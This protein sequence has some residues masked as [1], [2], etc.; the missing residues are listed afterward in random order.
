M[1]PATK[2]KP[3]KP[4]RPSRGKRMRHTALARD[5]IDF[6][7]G[8]RVGEGDMVGQPLELM[9]FQIDFIADAFKGGV[10]RAILSVARR[11]T[12]TA[13]VAIIVLAALIGPLMVPNSLIVSAARSRLQASVVFEYCKKMIRLSGLAAHFTIRDAAKEIVCE[14]FG[15]TYRALAAEATTAVGFGMRLCIHDEL[16][17]VEGPRDALFEALTTAMGSYKDSLEIIISTQAANDDDLFS[18]LIDDALKGD[19]PAVVCH[20]HTAPKDCKLDDREAWAA[21][22]PAMAYGVRD[23]ADMERQSREAMRLPSREAAFRN[24]ALNQRVRAIGHFIPPDIWDQGARAVDEEVLR[25]GPC[26]AGLD[27]SSRRDLTSLAIV[28]QDDAGE[29][30]ARVWAWT[31]EETMA[32]RERTDKVPYSQWVREGIVEAL[33]GSVIDYELIAARLG[34]IATEYPIVT[35]NFDR[36]KI[37]E[38]RLQL[39]KLGIALPL[40]EHGQGFK[41]F[42]GAV[43]ALETVALNGELRHGGNPVLRWAVAN[44]AVSRDHAGNRKFDKRLE[45]R[46]IDPAVAVAMAMRGAVRPLGAPEI[47]A[48]IA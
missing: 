2:A 16:G 43:D 26:Y 7:H 20:L 9:D 35:V 21:A 37:A 18:I 47:A 36:W 34:E 13:T 12:K 39:D 24:Y 3:T 48:L 38:L 17:Q 27:L 33:P 8:L 44:V 15:T 31:P 28:A 5:V 10:R 25:R 1:K 45:S 40:V 14:R 46:R 29:W 22:N 23:L 42:T 41:D 11:N 6:A 32:A 4:P 30:H 19:D